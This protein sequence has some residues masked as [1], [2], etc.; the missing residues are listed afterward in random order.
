MTTQTTSTSTLVVE[1]KNTIADG[2]VDLVLRSHAALPSWTP[3]AHVDLRLGHGLSRSYS[4]CG[5]PDDTTRYRLGILREPESRGG[6]AY[7][8]DKLAVGDTV[9]V[10][11]P[12]NH[13]ELLPSPCYQFIAGGIGITP[14]LPMIA[15]A[16]AA[17]ADWQLLYGGRSRDSMGF[18]DEL[19]V[20]GDRVT[21]QPQDEGGLLD[22]AAVL[23]TPREGTLVYSCGPTPL[24]DAVEQHCANWPAGALHVERFASATPA[25]REA[26]IAFEVEFARSGVTA[27][28][29]A[30]VSI[31]DVATDNGVFILRS[32]SEGVCGTCETELIEGDPDHRDFVLTPEDRA[33][34]CFMPCVS[35]ARSARLVLDL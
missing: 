8:H 22:L 30:G 11:G 5:P 12:T 20:F 26:D 4:L 15:A 17:G 6:S 28:V 2:V 31:L 1:S 3:G 18:L 9:E 34:G 32:C 21:V 29:E 23:G 16:E 33:A 7:V 25:H 24:L 14:L 19:A 10:V 13:F 27:T 35:R